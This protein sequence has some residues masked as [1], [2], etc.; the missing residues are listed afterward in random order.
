MA[1]AMSVDVSA[2]AGA[3]CPGGY[4]VYPF[5]GHTCEAKAGAKRSGDPCNSRD[6]AVRRCAR[7]AETRS[8][9]QCYVPRTAQ[10]ARWLR[11]DWAVSYRRGREVLWPT[12]LI[13]DL[14]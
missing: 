7:P 10:G 11:G 3:R 6:V 2:V 5:K 4:S 14:F 13:H 1:E 12:S 8:A 9:E